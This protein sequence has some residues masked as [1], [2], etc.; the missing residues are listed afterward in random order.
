MLPW[1]FFAYWI[2]SSSHIYMTMTSIKLDVLLVVIFSW[3][4]L[5]SH[6]YLSHNRMSLESCFLTQISNNLLCLLE[7]LIWSSVYART[8][9][10][11][12]VRTL[13]IQLGWIM[14]VHEESHQ[15]FKFNFTIV[16][17]YFH[18]LSMTSRSITDFAILRVV[19][20]A[21]LVSTCNL[22]HPI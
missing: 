4:E 12:A 6:F 16:K 11:T 19:N 9:L 15:S 13:S 22:V 10:G 20:L 17:N 21:L 7:L 1:H 18:A 14:H 3:P 5:L 2:K 8:V